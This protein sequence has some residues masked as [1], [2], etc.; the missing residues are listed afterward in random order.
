MAKKLEDP[1]KL[2]GCL[3]PG[4]GD[5]W[6]VQA[7]ADYLGDISNRHTFVSDAVICDSGGTLLKHKPIKVVCIESVHCG[8]SVRPVFDICRNALFTGDVDESRN[9]AV[10]AIAVHGWRKP[11]DRHARATLCQRKCS[12]FRFARERR[13][14]R[15]G[16]GR[17]GT[18]TSSQL[19]RKEISVKH[20]SSTLA[21]N[22]NIGNLHS[23]RLL[24]IELG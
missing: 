21:M 1:A 24:L 6:K 5:D 10:I 13:I 14:N 8:P 15:I 16:F 23:V 12:L 9:E 19:N 3:L 20:C 11:H 2:A 18:L 4:L 22:E 7:P 17:E